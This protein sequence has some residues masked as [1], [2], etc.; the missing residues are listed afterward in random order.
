MFMMLEHTMAL[1]LPLP[2]VLVNQ[3]KISKSLLNHR[4]ETVQKSLRL[5]SA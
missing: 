3:V 4:L 1:H 5:F 2:I